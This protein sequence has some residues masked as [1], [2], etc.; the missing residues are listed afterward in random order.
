MERGASSGVACGPFGQRSFDVLIARFFEWRA[1]HH[2]S[3]RARR[4]QSSDLGIFSRWCLERGI[5]RPDE[6]TR[7]VL[8]RYQRWLFYYRRK[9]GRPLTVRTQHARLV[10]VR[11]FFRWLVRERYLLSNPASDLVLPKLPMKL[12]LDGFRPDEVE[13]IL[14][15][16][17]VRD[18]LGVRDRAILE[19]L[20]STGVRR[21][22]LSAFDLWDVNTEKG[23]VSVRQGKG[24]KDRVV[25]IGDRALAWVA[26][27]VEDVRPQFVLHADEWAL[28]LAAEGGRLTADGLGNRVSQ[29]IK[30]SGVRPRYGSCHLFR[31]AMA[32][33]MLDN[34]ADIRY[35]QEI[36]GHARLDTTQL[37]TKVSIEKLKE[38]HSATHPA[39]MVRTGAAA[40][41]EE[42]AQDPEDASS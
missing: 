7:P 29:L 11:S 40:L 31:H 19:T 4:A 36:L 13:Q 16:P 17:D 24:R 20:Y 27:Y 10:C 12:P 3:Q 30:A 38:I 18:P 32:T 33:A 6:V 23:W 39:K 42:D 14:R 41:V 9:D 8:E 22:E 2:F 1:V 25:P 5:V 34:G 21:S 15:V 26:R 28:F 37:Y 35:L